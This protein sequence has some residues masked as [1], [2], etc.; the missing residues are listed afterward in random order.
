MGITTGINNG[1]V[2][3]YDQTMI[4]LLLLCV[5]SRICVVFDIEIFDITSL[6]LTTLLSSPGSPDKP[7]DER[8]EERVRYK[9]WNEAWDGS[10]CRKSL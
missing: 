3:N 10:W 5:V 2:N 4:A 1:E 7:Y 6:L 9:S 8:I